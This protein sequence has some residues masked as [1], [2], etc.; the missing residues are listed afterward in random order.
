MLSFTLGD[1][2]SGDGQ[3]SESKTNFSTIK[4]NIFVS[5]YML[6]ICVTCHFVTN[7]YGKVTG[8]EIRDHI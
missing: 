8:A 5:S 4:V 2:V 1:D 3:D 7:C 6:K